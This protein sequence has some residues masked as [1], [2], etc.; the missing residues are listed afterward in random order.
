MRYFLPVTVAA[1]TLAGC[2]EQPPGQRELEAG[3]RQI[4]RGEH[5]AALVQLQKSIAARP[6]SEQNLEAYNYLGIAHWKLGRTQDAMEAFESARRLS[7]IAPEPTYNLG[8]LCA[9]TADPARALQLLKDAALMDEKDPRPLEYMGAIY[10]ARQ[11]WPE[12]R[13]SLYA[14]R[15]RAPTSAR[16]LTAIAIVEARTEPPETAISSLLNA[17]GH[18]ANYAPAFFNLGLIYRTRLNDREH[19]TIYFRKFLD[20]VSTGPQADYAR[21]A[22]SEG[23]TPS[24]AA[25]PPVAPTPPLAAAVSNLPPPVTPRPP[26]AATDYAARAREAAERGRT[27]DAL[28]ICLQAAQQAAARNDRAGQEKALRTGV[29]VCIDAPRAHTELGNYLLAQGQYDAALRS[30]KTAVNLDGTFAPAFLGM[31]RA[32]TATKEY[33]SALVGLKQAVKTDP[34]NPDALWLLAQLYDRNIE[35]PAA[36][37]KAYGDFTKL[38]AS[39]SRAAYARDRL[40]K[41]G[42]PT[43]AAAAV[44]ETRP[45]VRPAPVPPPPPARTSM[46][47]QATAPSVAAPEVEQNPDRAASVRPAALTNAASAR[48]AFNRAAEYQQRNDWNNAIHYYEQAVRNDPALEV[49]WYNLGVGY[50]LRGDTAKA[51]DAY[52]RALERNPDHI[53][54]RYNLAVIYIENQDAAAAEKTLQDLLQRRPTYANAYLALGQIYARNPAT[55]PKAKAAYQQFLQLA[56]NE[57]AAASVRQWLSRP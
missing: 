36:A 17:L 39:D 1:L 16:I 18:D 15:S 7:P 4:R 3:V 43:L 45:T 51:K 35:M 40:K 24:G 11:Q 54:A 26:P 38:F 46:T 29:N 41:L 8:V 56:P 13:R 23:A 55:L 48:T 52:L 32:A 9:E 30:F 20:R 25:L 37:A 6:G 27:D 28:T 34:T 5:N 31:G 2:T 49:A 42:E 21:S 53:E 57:R 19:A 33:D 50:N 12:A 14:A 44:Q 22:L 10:T 47:I